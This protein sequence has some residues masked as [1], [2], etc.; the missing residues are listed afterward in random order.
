MLERAYTFGSSTAL[1]GILTSPPEGAA[2]S[3]APMVLLLNSG[4]IH[5]PGPFRMHVDLARRLAAMGFSVFRFDL[6]GIGDSEKHRDNRPREE[7]ILADISGAMDFLSS[8][9]GANRF[10]AMGLCT[11]ADNAHKISVRDQRVTGMVLLDGYCYPTALFYIRRY[12]PKLFNPMAWFRIAWRSVKKPDGLADQLASRR[13]DR[14]NNY[15]WSLPPKHQTESELKALVERR[16]NML[17]VFTNSSEFINYPGQLRDSMKSIDFG[18]HLQVEYFDEFE[19]TYPII[20]DRQCLFD[21]ISQ[22][23]RAKYLSPNEPTGPVE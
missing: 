12:G 8:N 13:D 5:R 15:F 17:Y 22:W 18:D 7:Q 20:R 16:V 19:H 6:S 9:M 23:M 21:L 2:V 3:G 10:V 14:E 1:I 11:G 4:L